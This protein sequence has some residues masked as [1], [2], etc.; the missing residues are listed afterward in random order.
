MA[1][2]VMRISATVT[3]VVCGALAVAGLAAKVELEPAGQA[4]DTA[5]VVSTND[6]VRILQK[7]TNL[8]FVGSAWK[9]YRRHTVFLDRDGTLKARFDLVSVFST[10]YELLSKLAE[11][12]VG[13]TVRLRKQPDGSF[14]YLKDGKDKFIIRVIHDE[15]APDHFRGVYYLTGERSFFRMEAL[16]HVESR[17]NR[18]EGIDYAAHVYANS[19]SR[20]LNL[21][22][23]IPFV[24]RYLAGEMDD[25]VAKFDVLY[26]EM[27]LD[28]RAN[29]QKLMKFRDPAGRIYF[30]DPDI[31]MTTRFVDT[32]LNQSPAPGVE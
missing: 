20:I 22:A 18:Q 13:S 14:L 16:L 12:L 10:E 8:T 17:P 29:L 3:W 23:R 6:L 31:E 27:L 24:K 7:A 19:D 5:L 28:P 2:F 32:L 11:C 15:S 30:S 1:G 25:V 9:T 21:L 26:A 4:P